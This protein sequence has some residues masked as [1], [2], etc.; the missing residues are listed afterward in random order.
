MLPV[1]LPSLRL[2]R[3]VICLQIWRAAPTPEFCISVGCDGVDCATFCG[4]PFPMSRF[5]LA[6]RT[7]ES[8]FTKMPVTS[9]L[10]E[11]L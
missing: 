7:G 10:V 5:P 2:R 11:R 6:T 1:C 9:W 3:G 4:K 8:D